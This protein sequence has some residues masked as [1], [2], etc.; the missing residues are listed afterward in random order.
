MIHQPRLSLATLVE[1]LAP[2]LL[3][4]LVPVG[5][6]LYVS[7]HNS[8]QRQ[9]DSSVAACERGN[10]L[11]VR[12]NTKFMVYDRAF[13]GAAVA[14]EDAKTATGKQLYGVLNRAATTAPEALPLTDC[15]GAYDAPKWFW[16]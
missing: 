3:V 4:L 5:A 13:A 8:K 9:F 16:E 2:V 10:K 15:A 1:W 11:R 12:I 6:A 7:D 14:L